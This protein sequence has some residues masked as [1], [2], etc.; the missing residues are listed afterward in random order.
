MHIWIGVGIV[1]LLIL[2][3]L[4]N[5]NVPVKGFELLEV[6]SFDTWRSTTDIQTRFERK[7]GVRLTVDQIFK[8]MKLLIESGLVD[9]RETNHRAEF[10]R[11]K[12]GK[13]E[14]NIPVTACPQPA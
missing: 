8:E 10:R 13:P 4:S 3:G 12:K 1:L 14:K 2:H 6:L 11:V 9:R 5:K 7:Y